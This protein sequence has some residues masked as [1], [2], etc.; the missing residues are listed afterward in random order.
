M[1]QLLQTSHSW[2]PLQEAL[3]QVEQ[4]AAQEEWREEALQEEGVWEGGMTQESQLISL[5][6]W[7]HLI[8]RSPGFTDEDIIKCGALD[9]FPSFT[10]DLIAKAESKLTPEQ[11]DDYYYSHLHKK[12]EDHSWTVSASK[13]ERLLALVKTIGKFKETQPVPV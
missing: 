5:F 10:L 11:R 8:A 7:M 9:N 13:E 2:F 12:D 1:L 3:P 4:V 6:E